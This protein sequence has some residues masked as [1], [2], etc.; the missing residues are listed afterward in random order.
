MLKTPAT[1]T[2]MTRWTPLSE[3]YNCEA[4]PHDQGGWMRV[5]R[6]ETHLS[7]TV[8]VG[9]LSDNRN[10]N[11]PTTAHEVTIFTTQECQEAR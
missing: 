7:L 2:S 6:A 4:G 9:A 10:S 11:S 1:Q 3:E 5:S 8:V